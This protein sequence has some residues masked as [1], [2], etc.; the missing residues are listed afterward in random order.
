MPIL[1]VTNRTATRLPVDSFVGILNPNQVRSVSL[2]AGELEHSTAVLVR[3]AEAGQITFLVNQ[4]PSQVDNAVEPVLGGARVARGSGDPEGVVVG[5][6]GDLFVRSDGG[7]GT[8]L[9][10]KESGNDTNTGWI[11]K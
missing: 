4:S 7:I 10:V 11:A 9:Y 1:V 5:V 8:T 6:V 3:L 2:T